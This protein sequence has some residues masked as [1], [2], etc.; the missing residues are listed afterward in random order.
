MNIAIVGYGIV[1]QA[2]KEV[3]CG[4]HDIMI[5]DPEKQQTCNYKNADVVLICTPT[6]QVKQYIEELMYHS[7]VYVRST[8]PME[9][10]EGTDIAVWPEFLTERSWRHDATHP[11]CLICG[12]NEDQLQALKNIT[13]DFVIKDYMWHHTD[14]VTAAFMKNATNTF[15]TMKVSF[16]NILYETCKIKKMSYYKLKQ[17]IKQDPRMGGMHWDV[18]GPDGEQGFGGKCF[19]ANLE[20]MRE[21]CSWTGRKILSHIKE[22]N[23]LVRGHK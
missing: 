1:G 13:S 6:D 14:N 18:P 22:F 23:D 12:G 16:A 19:P 3:I 21:Q 2:T 20:I 11:I 7:Y 8:I 4:D 17:C 5:H 10:V 15:Y 9:Y